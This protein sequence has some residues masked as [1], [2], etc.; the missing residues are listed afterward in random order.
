[1]SWFSNEIMRTVGD[2][3][4]NIIMH[5]CHRIN[6]NNILNYL[7][8]HKNSCILVMYHMVQWMTQD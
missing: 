8:R 4:D 1:M 6:K 7:L 3:Y 5:N 2:E